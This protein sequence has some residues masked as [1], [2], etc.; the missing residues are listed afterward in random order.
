M[1][2][3]M[4][5]GLAA[6]LFAA[7]A[8][9]AAPAS[10]LP[11]AGHMGCA[12]V[13]CDVAAEGEG[14]LHQ[15]ASRGGRMGSGSNYRPSMG[16]GYRGGYRGG[17]YRGAVNRGAAYRGGAYRGGAYRSAYR[18]GNRAYRGAGYYGKPGVRADRRWNRNARYAGYGRY[19]NRWRGGGGGY[20]SV[21][22]Y[23]GWGWGYADPYWGY[24]YADPYYYGDGYGVYA[25]VDVN[26][27]V[28][29]DYVAYCSRKYKSFNPRTGLYRTYSGQYKKCVYTG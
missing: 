25:D 28:D 21:G 1:K 18:G 19:P 24:G 26:V 2:I 10:A 27:N 23:P 15:A 20:W 22:V 5:L 9:I 13:G 29:S 11:A 3:G 16:G 4:G 6:M 17:A 8:L 12:A 14:L 7:Q